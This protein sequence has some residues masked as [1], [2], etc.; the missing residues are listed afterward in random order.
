M[1]FPQ[2]EDHDDGKYTRYLGAVHV[3]EIPSQ[4][5]QSFLKALLKRFAKK[6][7]GKQRPVGIDFYYKGIPDDSAPTEKELMDMVLDYKVMEADHK[8]VLDFATSVAKRMREVLM[9]SDN[10]NLD[11][12]DI[13]RITQEV[14]DQIAELLQKQNS[15]IEKSTDVNRKGFNSLKTID[16]LSFIERIKKLPPPPQFE[17]EDENWISEET[18]I[19]HTGE[20]ADTLKHQR[21]RGDCYPVLESVL[22]GEE[23]VSEIH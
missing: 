17:Q 5:R 7:N 22:E 21:S 13:T 6:Y 19:K 1:A 20:K 18:L 10:Q 23:V 14:G 8:E 2:D 3:G 4:F 11:I 16:H 9:E 15:L 12:T